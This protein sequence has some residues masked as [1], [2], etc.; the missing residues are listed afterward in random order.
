MMDSVG[1]VLHVNDY[2][3]RPL[4]CQEILLYG[5]TQ[6]RLTTSTSILFGGYL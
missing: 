6:L 3:K 2:R 1:D 4:L 5:V